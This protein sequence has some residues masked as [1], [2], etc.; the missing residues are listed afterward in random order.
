MTYLLPSILVPFALIVPSKRMFV[1]A[2]LTLEEN[3]FH[4]ELKIN[5]VFVLL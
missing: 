2:E 3:I 5:A 1:F 4:K